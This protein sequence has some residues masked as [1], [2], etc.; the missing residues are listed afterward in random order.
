MWIRY[1]WINLAE[2]RA[3]KDCL[4]LQHCR[5]IIY[6]LIGQSLRSRERATLL[7]QNKAR[8]IMKWWEV[9]W[10]MCWEGKLWFKRC[11]DLITLS[12]WYLKPWISISRHYC[13]IFLAVMESPFP[14]G[15][16]LLISKTWTGGN[17]FELVFYMASRRIMFSKWLLP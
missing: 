15:Q 13:R 3:D 9:D 2:V 8:L 17:I 5:E 16:A 14:I 1:S 12:D 7:F 10:R 11:R 6:S 4:D